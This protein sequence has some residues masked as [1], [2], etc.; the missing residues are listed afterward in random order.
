M[1]KILELLQKNKYALIWTVCYIF[2]VWA[3]LKWMFNF[4]IFSATQWHILFHAQ[5]RGFPGFVF[6]I[7]ILAAI[8]MYI[9]TTNIILRTKK[10][11]FRIPLPEFLRP[12]PDE[13]KSE[14]APSEKLDAPVSVQEQK[15]NDTPQKIIPPE[16]RAAFARARLHIGPTPKSNFD[17]SNLAQTTPSSAPNNQQEMQPVDEL[18]LPTDFDIPEQSDNAPPSFVPVF[19]DLNFDDQDAAQPPETPNTPSTQNTPD[20]L[21]PIVKHLEQNNI[22]FEIQN[23]IILTDR[24]AIAAHNDPDFWIADDGTWFAAGKQKPSPIDTI[25]AAGAARGVRPVLYLG[26]TNIMD[27]EA[28]RAQWSG[29]GVTVITDISEIQ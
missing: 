18:P 28:R 5:L 26:Y 3:I 19:S 11:L 9:A 1:K 20:D 23:G 13:K 15:Q 21:K 12:V 10:P 22:K 25:L 27:F 24:D 14:N 16:M 6:G 4:S 17:I 29:N 2:I 7:L 8:P